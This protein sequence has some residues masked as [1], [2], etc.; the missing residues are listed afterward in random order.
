MTSPERPAI[1]VQDGKP[2]P[3]VAFRTFDDALDGAGIYADEVRKGRCDQ[4]GIIWLWSGRP[5]GHNPRKACSI[6]E[7]PLRATTRNAH[8]KSWRWWARPERKEGRR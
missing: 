2:A 3:S 6:C 4:C 1:A 7:T 8:P 5:V